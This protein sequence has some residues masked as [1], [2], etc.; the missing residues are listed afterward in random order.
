[1]EPN[2]IFAITAV[3]VVLAAVILTYRFG[4]KRRNEFIFDLLEA[5][6]EPARRPIFAGRRNSRPRSDRGSPRI[7]SRIGERT[8]AR[9]LCEAN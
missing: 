5:V 4:P 7:S 1:M 6:G 9:A 8:V 2:I 3:V